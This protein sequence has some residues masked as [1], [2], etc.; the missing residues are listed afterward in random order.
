MFVPWVATVQ[1]LL[2]AAQFSQSLG[3]CAR[4]LFNAFT[5]GGH[6]SR[7]RG[8]WLYTVSVCEHCVLFFFLHVLTIS[9]IGMS[10]LSQT[11]RTV[12][13]FV[14]CVCVCVCLLCVCVCLFAV[15]VCLFAV[16]VCVCL[17]C[18]F[19]LLYVCLFA[20]CVCLLCVCV[21]VCLFALCVCLLYVC[22]CVARER[23]FAVCSLLRPVGSL[24]RC[25]G[26][27]R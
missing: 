8:I 17:L 9:I 22:V 19:V 4:T 23:E 14:C 13:V 26:G 16:C 27:Q 25:L 5:R 10:T 7:C 3:T 24:Q 1:G 21:C 6:W 18:V 20:V 2:P 15:C 11:L 12:C